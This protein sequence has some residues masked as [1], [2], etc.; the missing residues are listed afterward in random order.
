[1]VKRTGKVYLVGAGPG[2]PDLLTVK[3]ARVL[4]RAGAVVYDRLVSASVLELAPQDAARVYVGKAAGDHH[5]PQDRINDLLLNLARSGLR[6]VRLKGG[7]PLI[8]GRGSEEAR[9]LQNH[10]V[11]FEI[12]P[13]ITAASG[14]SAALGLP[15][16]HRGLASGVRYVTGHCRA[17]TDLDLDW[18]GLADPD[19]TLVLY[20]GLANLPQIAGRLMAEG[21]SPAT[22]VAAVA[23]ATTE[24]QRQAVTTLGNA[25]SAMAELDLPAPVLFIIGR[26]VSL[27]D[28]LNWQGLVYEDISAEPVE[29]QTVHA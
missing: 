24:G 21:L 1:M 3:A 19:T 16:T 10:G 15:L 14:V 23:S 13:G 18:K 6:V 26:V 11:E 20:M 22:P 27:A 12:V 28:A 4:G 5:L 7:D 2:D 17:D 9:H 8:F 25:V 29:R